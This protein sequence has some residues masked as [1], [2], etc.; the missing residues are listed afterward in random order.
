MRKNNKANMYLSCIR[1]CGKDTLKDDGICPDCYEKETVTPE[2]RT[3]APMPPRIG[4]TK[5]SA[6]R[7]RAGHF[8]TEARSLEHWEDSDGFEYI[9]LQEHQELLSDAVKEARAEA[10][11]LVEFIYR[12]QTC[13]MRMVETY[14]K[15]KEAAR[16]GRE[17]NG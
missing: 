9:S 8:I 5:A 10:F 12:G 15:L 3:D 13:T 1:K 16:A 7:L 4:I 2:S 14:D 6:R 11:E 17:T